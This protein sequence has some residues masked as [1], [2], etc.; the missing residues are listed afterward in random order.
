MPR[1]A[2]HHEISGLEGGPESWARQA[3][4]DPGD[5]MHLGHILSPCAANSRAGGAGQAPQEAVP[6]WGELGS[7]HA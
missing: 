3:M 1:H 2:H 7:E 6:Q 4:K 5:V